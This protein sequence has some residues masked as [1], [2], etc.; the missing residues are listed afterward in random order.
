MSLFAQ[1]PNASAP[2]AFNSGGKRNKQATIEVFTLTPSRPVGQSIGVT[3]MIVAPFSKQNTFAV[4]GSGAQRVGADLVL[5]LQEIDAADKASKR[6]KKEA[7]ARRPCAQKC[8]LTLGSVL[9]I[10]QFQMPSLLAHHVYSINIS[11]V[12]IDDYFGAK[13]FKYT[14]DGPPKHVRAYADMTPAEHDWLLLAIQAAGVVNEPLTHAVFNAATARRVE[15]MNKEAMDAFKKE[16]NKQHEV[17]TETTCCMR[18]SALVFPR[19]NGIRAGEDY[20]YNA[21][22]FRGH[23]TGSWAEPA[24]PLTT[25]E[26]WPRM[27]TSDKDNSIVKVDYMKFS[28]GGEQNVPRRGFEDVPLPLGADEFRVVMV[29]NELTVNV[30]VGYGGLMAYGVFDP[31]HLFGHEFRALVHATPTLVRS[32]I[33]NGTEPLLETPSATD[34]IAISVSS[35]GDKP[36][37]GQ[38]VDTTGVLLDLAV[39][40]VNAGYRIDAASV[41]ALFEVLAAN[42]PQRYG[43][44]MGELSRAGWTDDEGKPIQP[45][46]LCT[47]PGQKRILNLLEYNHRIDALTD[48]TWAFFII[49]NGGQKSMDV[50]AAD[51]PDGTP[52]P[53]TIG[54]EYY[55]KANEQLGADAAAAKMGAIF[56]KIAADDIHELDKEARLAFQKSIPKGSSFQYL[57]FAV[58]KDYMEARGLNP[59]STLNHKPILMA[60]G[61]ELYPEDLSEL[62][63]GAKRINAWY[64][65]HSYENAKRSGS[66]SSSSTPAAKR[67]P[68][69]PSGEP[70]PAFSE[71]TDEELA[72]A[73][74]AQ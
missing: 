72:D 58:R 23:K 45:N 18:N 61:R 56:V 21:H 3:A 52:A 11:A 66:S 14:L 31:R 70:G 19:I 48:D 50:P 41:L 39:G 15:C 62:P 37:P 73:M 35:S 54:F 5:D 44:D 8:L 36:K 47:D 49:P 32:Y 25:D 24:L 1:R 20:V 9:Q 33:S 38:R 42:E 46:P 27:R 55:R 53:E 28:L 26:A 29:T 2:V 69:G 67:V 12:D 63:A 43:V 34:K 60:R 7:A 16:K 51:A 22:A 17:Y 68:D 57:L 40:I 65:P 30:L 4:H 74:D 59:L 64:Y 10:V 13:S 71:M 6:G